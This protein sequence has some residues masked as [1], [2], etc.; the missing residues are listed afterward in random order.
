MTSTE[1]VA[2]A[3]VAG[4]IDAWHTISRPRQNLASGQHIDSVHRQLDNFERFSNNLLK[5]SLYF[6]LSDISAL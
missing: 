6:S 5:R 4:K 1:A 2:K 3:L